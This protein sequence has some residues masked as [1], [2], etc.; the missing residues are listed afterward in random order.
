MMRPLL[1]VLLAACG[2]TPAPQQPAPQQPVAQPAT[3]Q[4]T[5]PP[6]PE[7]G[8]PTDL[9]AA[10]GTTCPT[11]GHACNKRAVQQATGFSNLIV[12][13]QAKWTVVEVP[14]PAPK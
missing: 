7:A 3:A 10:V 2:S 12:C 1:L 9:G 14:P 8:C 6:A 13:R 5:T 11:E 4:P